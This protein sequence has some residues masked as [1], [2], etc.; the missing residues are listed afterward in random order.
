M[1]GRR[2]LHEEEA[3]P[4]YR[5]RQVERR[6]TREVSWEV[7]EASTGLTVAGGLCDREEALRIVRGWERLNQKKEGGLAGHTLVH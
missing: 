6:R 2:V 4:N 5:I 3:S 1:I 7:L